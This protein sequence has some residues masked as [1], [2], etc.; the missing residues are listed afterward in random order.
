M[1]SQQENV[2]EGS[3]AGSGTHFVSG[4]RSEATRRWSLLLGTPPRPRG[5]PDTSNLGRCGDCSKRTFCMEQGVC[6]EWKAA[7]ISVANKNHS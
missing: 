4:I 5:L 1:S 3:W 6:I 7:K 2:T